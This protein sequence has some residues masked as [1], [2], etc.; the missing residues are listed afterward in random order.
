MYVWY[1][2]ERDVTVNVIERIITRCNKSQFTEKRSSHRKYEENEAL[3]LL[4][5]LLRNQ[6]NC[7]GFI[8]EKVWKLGK[9]NVNL[10]NCRRNGSRQ[11]TDGHDM[12]NNLILSQ[13]IFL[14][15]IWLL[16]FI[17]SIFWLCSLQFF[18]MLFIQR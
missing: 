10:P 16:I 5:H 11:L 13:L 2:V 15:Y 4:S 8:S 14:I 7:V 12:S 9:C 1:S 6:R 18:Y 17:L 3:S